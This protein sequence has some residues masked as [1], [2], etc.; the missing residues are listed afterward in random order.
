LS[1]PSLLLRVALLLLYP[2]LRTARNGNEL[3][4]ECRP[5][6]VESQPT[7]ATEVWVLLNRQT[8]LKVSQCCAKFTVDL[9]VVETWLDSGCGPNLNLTPTAEGNVLRVN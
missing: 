3:L 5:V 7:S 1:L 9:G 2:R 4:S 6:C 8:Y